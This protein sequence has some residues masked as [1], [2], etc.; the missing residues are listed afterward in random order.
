MF[1]SCWDIN[2]LK[3]LKQFNFKYNKIASAMI[4]NIKLLKEV[5]KERKKTFI[6]TGMCMMKDIERAVRIFKSQKCEFVLMHSVS[7]YPCDENLLNL[8]FIKTLK[9]KFNC[10][11]GYSGHES[12]ISPS[13]TAFFLGAD[14]IERHITLDRAKWGTDQASSLSESGIESLTTVIKKIPI[15]LGDGKKKFL[16][17][18]KNVRKKML[19]WKQEQV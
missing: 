4:T 18:E 5:A 7:L 16:K 15:T 9:K 10:E 12:T 19:Y 14:Y 11:V 13:I 3:Q 2:S 17:E 6:S 1:A 8:N